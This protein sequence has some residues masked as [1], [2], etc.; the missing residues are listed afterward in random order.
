[1]REGVI[2]SLVYEIDE[3]VTSCD[4]LFLC[5]PV[6]TNIELLHKLKPFLNKEC[7]ITDVGSVKGN[8]QKEA[9]R[10]G[11]EKNFIGGHPMA[12]SE[13]TGYANSTARLLKNS[14]Y[15]LTP[16]AQTSEEH[17]SQLLSLLACTQSNCI[18]IDPETHDDVTAA[19][20]HIPHRRCAR[21]SRTKQR[22]RTFLYENICRR[23]FS[24]YYT[25]R[26]ILSRHVAKHLPVQ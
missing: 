23:R 1:M 6:L 4:I 9:V 18:V 26:F 12:G 11:M 25:D 2:D 7:I 21:K 17:L 14:Y 3:W 5:A 16:T 13:K 24:R 8:I 20:S 22:R 19:I 15:L 10:L